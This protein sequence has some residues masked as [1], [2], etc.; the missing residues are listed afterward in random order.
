MT[1]SHILPMARSF[2]QNAEVASLGMILRGKELKSVQEVSKQ[3][4][5]Q[6]M[7]CCVNGSDSTS[8]LAWIRT[9]TKVIQ[10]R[11]VRLPRRPRVFAALGKGPIRAAFHTVDR[12][13]VVELA[14]TGGYTQCSKTSDAIDRNLRRNSLGLTLWK[15]LPQ[16]PKRARS[17][18]T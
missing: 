8:C 10:S 15:E 7:R 2:T 11:F 17:S 14:R 4:Y 1:R 6:K 9:M 3:A 12:F 5:C 18:E 13:R 16:F